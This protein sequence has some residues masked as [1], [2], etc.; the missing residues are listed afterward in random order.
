M[1]PATAT[2]R[3]KRPPAQ[4]REPIVDLARHQEFLDHFLV[5]WEITSATSRG[6]GATARTRAKGGG[7][8]DLIEASITSATDDEIVLESR[9]GRNGSRRMRLAYA[10]GEP[11]PPA[12]P[13]DPPGT[14]TQVKFTLELLQGSIVD[15]ATWALPRGH[16]ERMYGQALLRLKGL[17]EG[18]PRSL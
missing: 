1:K 10:L 12:V 6:A 3:I 7:S 8:D 2:V 15:Q 14:A 9:S 11:D 18:E 17:V 5:D 4:V 13:P 16:L